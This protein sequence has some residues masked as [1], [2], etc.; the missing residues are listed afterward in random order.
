MAE[1]GTSTNG[2]RFLVSSFNA[3]F[4]LGSV[5]N[6]DL[7]SVYFIPYTNLS[8]RIGFIIKPNIWLNKN[9]WNLNGDLRIIHNEMRTYGLGAD[10]PEEDENTI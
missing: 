6:T 7:S 9:K 8:S 5:R 10:S 3:T 4:R 1:S 2:N